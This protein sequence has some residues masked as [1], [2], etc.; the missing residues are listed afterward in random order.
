MTE[1]DRALITGIVNEL[2][3]TAERIAGDKALS[4]ELVLSQVTECER[5]F[6]QLRTLLD[7]HGIAKAKDG[8]ETSETDDAAC[9]AVLRALL[10][11]AGESLQHCIT[12]LSIRRNAV[13]EELESMRRA[14]RA[15]KAYR[16]IE[17]V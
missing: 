7:R 16:G 2:I 1:S 10:L 13:A 9:D 5:T 17:T 14:Q 3:R 15:T 8:P 11:Q 4:N 12:A 6:A